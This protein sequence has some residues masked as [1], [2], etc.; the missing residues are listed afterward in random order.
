MP[1]TR[2]TFLKR[3]A[4]AG[5]AGILAACSRD[6]P[7]GYPPES[8]EPGY[9]RLEA[10]GQLA[11][12]V[13]RAYRKFERCE[14]CPRRCRVNRRAGET[15]FCNA[16][17]QVK[18]Y[19]HHPHFG[20]E[21][22]LVGRRGSGTIFFSN[23]NLRCVFCQNWPIAHVGLGQPVSDENLAEMMLDLQARGCHNINVVTPT[24]VMPNIVAAVR[25][26]ALQGLRLP[27]CY[28][29]GG[30]ERMENIA[31]LD[32]IVDIYLPDLKFMDGAESARYAT[33]GARDY[34]EHAQS[35]ILE[36]QRQV[37]RLVTDD[38][39]IALRGLMLRH[40]VMPNRVAG[41]KAF[42]DWVAANLPA[43]TYVNIMAQYR[44]EHRAFEYE[45][46]ARAITSEEFLEAM[47]WAEQA[48]LT[49]LDERSLAQAALH[50]RRRI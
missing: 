44:V 19:S 46:I 41:S 26:A 45:A 30:Y 36:M 9:L 3:M 49:N 40:L 28:N 48:G 11:D 7:A 20:E 29:T 50:R 6:T 18:I 43:D 32:G 47:D 35:A 27:I 2:R 5:G 17:D 42:V 31:L 25:I 15:G 16:T 34:P 8:W 14:L 24:H 38:N 13:E 33:A 4:V 21:L 12:R 23:C 1:V 39:G 37:G 22:P 10:D